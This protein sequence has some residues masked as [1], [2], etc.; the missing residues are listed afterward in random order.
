MMPKYRVAKFIRDMMNAGDNAEAMA[1]ELIKSQCEAVSKLAA[2]YNK[3]VV[4]ASFY[5]RDEEFVV[6]L[7][8]HNF[9]ILPSPERAV[10]AMAALAAYAR[11][12]SF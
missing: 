5:T 2:Q 11:M 12:R 8:D 10:K 6:N 7:Q 1:S 3:P 4:G 9:A